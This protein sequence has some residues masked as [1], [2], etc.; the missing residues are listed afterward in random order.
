MIALLLLSLCSPSASAQTVNLT[1]G[2]LGWSSAA[3]HQLRPT[4]LLSYHQTIKAL[5]LS[6]ELLVSQEGRKTSTYTY[7]TIPIR[8]AAL[9]EKRFSSDDN[10]FFLSAGPSLAYR[11]GS[12]SSGNQ[13]HMI[14]ELAPGLRL[15]AGLNIRLGGPVDLVWLSGV[16]GRLSA[17]DYDSSLGLGVSW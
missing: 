5:D 8:V 11:V 12:L 4:G 15:R 14:H 7:M 6:A 9:I 2:L 13:H 3:N 10:T 17:V 1:G 16:N